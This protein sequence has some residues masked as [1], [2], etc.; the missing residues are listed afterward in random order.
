MITAVKIRLMRLWLC[1]MISC[2]IGTNGNE[3]SSAAMYCLAGE[4]TASFPSIT[5]L[6]TADTT[7]DFV[8][9]RC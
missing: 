8:G 1:T 2:H 4:L 5:G 6:Q 7:R 3:R 9:V